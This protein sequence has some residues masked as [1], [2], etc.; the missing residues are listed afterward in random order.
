MVNGLRECQ[1][2]FLGGVIVL[3]YTPGIQLVYKGFSNAQEGT[4]SSKHTKL[5]RII[6]NLETVRHRHEH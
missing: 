1:V 5:L 4:F 2:R 6:F 3:F